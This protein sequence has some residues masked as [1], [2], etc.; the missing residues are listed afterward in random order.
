MKKDWICL[1]CGWRKNPVVRKKATKEEHSYWK[2]VYGRTR[3]L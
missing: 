1:N 2:K 3:D